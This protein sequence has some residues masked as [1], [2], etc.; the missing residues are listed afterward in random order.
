MM[1]VWLSLDLA[2]LGTL[3]FLT[4]PPR[5]IAGVLSALLVAP[6]REQRLMPDALQLGA[7]RAETW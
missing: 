1:S 5:T 6:L 4:A 2:W 3:S 7:R